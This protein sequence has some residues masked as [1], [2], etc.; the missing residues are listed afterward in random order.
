[1]HV[2]SSPSLFAFLTREATA[3]AAVGAWRYSVAESARSSGSPPSCA[4]LRASGWDC[5]VSL[6]SEG[7]VSLR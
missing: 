1:M 7:L 6:K 5:T 3:V 2:C 4:Q